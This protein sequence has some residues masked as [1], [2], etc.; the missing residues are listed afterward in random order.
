MSDISQLIPIGQRNKV[1]IKETK[2]V[3]Y[4]R[5]NN[6]DGNEAFCRYTNFSKFTETPTYRCSDG[7]PGERF[8]CLKK[9][10]SRELILNYPDKDVVSNF[11]EHGVILIQER[12]KEK[13]YKKGDI[14]LVFICA[15][16]SSSALP[17]DKLRMQIIDCNIVC[18]TPDIILLSPSI[19]N[20]CPPYERFCASGKRVR[21]M[22]GILNGD[23]VFTSIQNL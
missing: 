5:F 10:A 21:R 18:G 4:V 1:T 6:P 12:M 17:S 13:D 2:N 19:Q 11:P 15:P 20:V 23:P 3:I 7:Y 16:L 22:I 14:E 9:V 8:K